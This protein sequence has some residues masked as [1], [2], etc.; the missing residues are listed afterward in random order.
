MLIIIHCS[1]CY[2]LAY[3]KCSSFNVHE[4]RQHQCFISKQE[5]T[6]TIRQG[7]ACLSTESNSYNIQINR[8]RRLINFELTTDSDISMHCCEISKSL[9][10]VATHSSTIRFSH[11]KCKKGRDSIIK[12][13]RYYVFHLF[14]IICSWL[15]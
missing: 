13:I 1:I 15:K 11:L 14:I 8:A 7:S 2:T 12:V 4:S 5:S 9:K 10:G 6:F 3:D